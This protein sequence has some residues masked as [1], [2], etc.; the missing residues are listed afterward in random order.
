MG[1]CGPKEREREAI[2]NIFAIAYNTHAQDHNTQKHCP[3]CVCVYYMYDNNNC[4]ISYKYREIKR[5]I[6]YISV[7]L[8]C[9]YY[10]RPDG[11]SNNNTESLYLLWLDV[12]KRK[13]QL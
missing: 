4:I 8:F 7:T 12:C 9:V 11:G 6:I 2:R 10:F 13:H 1:H 3:V 5:D